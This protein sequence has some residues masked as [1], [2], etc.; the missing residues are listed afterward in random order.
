MKIKH[1]VIRTIIYV[2]VFTT[3]TVSVSEG[4]VTGQLWLEPIGSTYINNHPDDWLSESWTIGFGSFKLNITNHDQHDAIY[5]LYIITA[6]NTDPASTSINVKVNN[7]QINNW[8]PA[9]TGG[10][11]VVP[12]TDLFEYPPHGIYQDGTW[13]SIT[14]IQIPGG[15]PSDTNITI[16]VE[17]S[18]DS[19]VKIHF[20]G[21]GAD[22]SNKALVFV[23]PSHDVTSFIPEFPTIILPV[24][25]ALGIMLLFQKRKKGKEE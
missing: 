25:A 23:P 2:L 10:K 15:L 9:S 6:V 24:A 13:Y 11:I 18:G 17:T 20:D 12:T 22:N 8:K 21:V 19:N 7:V 5:T 4:G 1:P 14:Q 16:P 3:L